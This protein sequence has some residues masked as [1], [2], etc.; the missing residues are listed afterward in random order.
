VTTAADLLD[1]EFLAVVAD[2]V[3]LRALVLLEEQPTD[4]ATL[5]TDAGL[6]SEAMASHVQVLEERGLVEP[7]V[8][9]GDGMRWRTRTS[10]WIKLNELIDRIGRSG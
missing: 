2:P 5:A 8:A 7:A 4:L 9:N 1:E 10:G 3:R 6:S